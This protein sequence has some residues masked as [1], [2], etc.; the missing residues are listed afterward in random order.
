MIL[1]RRHTTSSRYSSV[2]FAACLAFACLLSE[3]LAAGQFRHGVSA[4]LIE[5]TQTSQIDT[6][7]NAS[8]SLP[9]SINNFQVP[10]CS[11]GDYDVRI[12]SGLEASYDAGRGVL[13][14]SVAEN[15]RDN[16]GTNAYPTSSFAVSGGGYRIVTWA[17]TGEYNVNVA[18]AWF[19]FDRYLGGVAWNSTNLNGGV[20]DSFMG[21]PGLVLGTHVKSLG[22]G[23]F[24]VDLRTRGVDSR[25]DGV[26]LV[27]H[28]KDENNFAL[29]QAN[30]A[31][32]TWN[33]FLHD[34]VQS[35]ANSYEQDPVAFVFVPKTNTDLI[36]GRFLG[37]GAISM[38]SGS[39]PQFS[40]S[41]LE[42]GRW[43]LTIPGHSPTNGVLI[44][45][46]EG[47]VSLNIDNIVSYAPSAA[48][49]GWVIESRDTPNNA[50]Q[51]VGSE[52]VASF[53]FIPPPAPGFAVTPANGLATV[54]NGGTD[55]FSV[56]L[57]SRPAADVRINL[58]SSDIAKGFPTPT[59]LKF[60]SNTWHLPQTVT[61]TGQ[62]NSDGLHE[63]TYSIVLAAA[64][65]PD[66][67]YNGLKASDVSV[68]F[69][70]AR[71]NPVFPSNR[72][73]DAGRSAGLK[74]SVTNTAPGDLTVTF[75]GRQANTP[76]PGEDF[77]I[78][79]LP[80]AQCYTAEINGGKKEMFIS[81]VEWII[82]NR[83]ERNIVYVT[84]LGDISN[85][86]D[87]YKGV[88]NLAQW[89][90]VTNAMYRQE[91]PVRT[92]LLHGIP[93]GV[94]VGN[95]EMTPNG[96]PVGGTTSFYNQYFGVSH[97]LGR[98]YYGGHY[99]TNNNNHFDFFSAG[100]LE[101]IALYFE[102][103]DG[104]DPAALAWAN[105]VLKTNAN[106]RAFAITHNMGNA[107]TPVVPSAQGTAIYNAL[108]TNSNFFMMLGGHISGEGCREDVF[109][110]RTIRTFVQDY[111]SR[112][113]GG[114]GLLRLLEF[115]PSNNVVVA[116][117]YSPWLKQYETDE[118]SEFFFSY[119]MQPGGATPSNT[120]FA[121]LSTNV[122]VAP[123]SLVSCAWPGLQ[124]NQSYEWFVT[125]SD[126]A[127]LSVTSAVWNFKTA[128]TNTPPVI[129]NIGKT[130]PGDSMAS[131]TLTATDINGDP[132]TF[133]M[134]TLPTRGLVSGFD[135]TN[136]A[137]AYVPA[138]GYRGA[139]RF[140]F[141]ARD[142]QAASGA[143]TMNL[144]IISPPD[145]NSNGLPDDWELAYG[146]SDPGADD[147]GDGVSN[148]DE[149]AGN[150]NPTNA[151]SVFKIISAAP[152]TNG[153]FDLTWSSVGGT[154][155]RVEF[156]NGGSNSGAGG[157]FSEIVRGLASEMDSN[158]VGAEATQVFVDDAALTGPPTNNT[159][160]YRVK[161][162]Q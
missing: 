61:V 111:Q 110:G 76:N 154:R 26:L 59:T 132:L 65:S 85:N 64:V 145:T 49:D 81:Q 63:S 53:V 22:G 4:G 25:T 156:S 44:V 105:Q 9:L 112:A 17:G 131:L 62:T 130:I 135:P 37:T 104:G 157:G 20:T 35:S 151:S 34:N 108:R 88:P 141:R 19:P 41:N 150:T 93:Y 120:V 51:A 126:S 48:G 137:V 160:Y 82:T 101:F 60:S 125:V 36:S 96:D 74:A 16:F 66:R 107:Q 30:G 142:G 89:M 152:R 38:F 161:V 75:F 117:T 14:T 153:V 159:R 52:P 57:L 139:D 134:P 129:V 128:L 33:V 15:G 92:K 80:D 116:Q 42:A 31:D 50:L 99:G 86:G 136:G 114:N 43:L 106:R 70:P 40:V 5:V 78:V 148:I 155:Y 113:G 56:V 83:V 90:N 95:H 12:G 21:S 3:P 8:V 158:P 91:N 84:Q 146:V 149:Y 97:F 39:S 11:R 10:A 118:D 102:Y 7:N 143:A 127:G 55:T 94:A 69:K 119:N 71:A 2:G 144:N 29:A 124:T 54:G 13:I 140:T 1:L 121:A 147:D 45:S 162:V 6:N 23:K 68:Q 67:G 27:N 98:S 103:Y 18:G 47:G 100:G 32:G 77:T 24:I 46:P 73:L 115:S 123:G 28:A 58:A 72:Y 109:E 122:G 138:R 79:V 87:V 133:E